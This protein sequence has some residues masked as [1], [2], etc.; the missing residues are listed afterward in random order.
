MRIKI[1]LTVKKCECNADVNV[2]LVN[3]IKVLLWRY[4]QAGGSAVC[5]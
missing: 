1:F 2:K 3:D 4:M 5:G